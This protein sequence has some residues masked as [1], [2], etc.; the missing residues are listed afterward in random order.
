[1]V[2]NICSNEA[3][4]GWKSSTA[5]SHLFNR[6]KSHYNFIKIKFLTKA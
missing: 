5:P 1:M 2:Q 3:N 4:K 6:L